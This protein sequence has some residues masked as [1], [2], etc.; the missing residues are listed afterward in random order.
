MLRKDT[1]TF[2]PSQTKNTTDMIIKTHT[3][4][5]GY[6]VEV[7]EGKF[8]KYGFEYDYKVEIS[9]AGYKVATHYYPEIQAMFE[10]CWNVMGW[11]Q[12]RPSLLD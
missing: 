9:A 6:T 3:F 10:C 1:L 7:H 4:E 8:D 5:N 12:H 11:E 2:V